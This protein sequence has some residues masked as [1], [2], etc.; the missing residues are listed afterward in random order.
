MI[1]IPIQ[2]NTIAN[3]LPVGLLKSRLNAGFLMI[4]INP[5]YIHLCPTLHEPCQILPAY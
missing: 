5:V 4:V 1:N 3:K 2:P